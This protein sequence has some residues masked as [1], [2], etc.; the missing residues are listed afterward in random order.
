MVVCD[1]SSSTP[2]ADSR[3]VALVHPEHHRLTARLTGHKAQPCF[4]LGTLPRCRILRRNI[5]LWQHLDLTWFADWFSFIAHDQL[6]FRFR[7]P[8][9]SI[10]FW[11]CVRTAQCM[12]LLTCF[13]SAGM[14]L[15]AFSNVLFLEHI[16]QWTVMSCFCMPRS[17]Y[18]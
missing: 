1:C 6:L 3:A 15:Q 7:S 13:Q 9:L 18:L 17:L 8:R 12:A 14:T 11:V 5:L 10:R 16:S 2:A 4:A